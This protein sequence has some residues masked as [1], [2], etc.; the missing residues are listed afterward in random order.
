MKLTAVALAALLPAVA[1]VT[2]I[3][4][5]MA[6]GNPSAPVTIQVYSDYECPACKTFHDQ[7]LPE[8]VR[9][10]VATGKVYLIYRN[11]PLPMHPYSRQ[12]AGYACAAAHLKLFQPVAD[13]LFRNQSAWAQTGKVWEYVASVLTE[14]QQKEVETMAKS[15]EVL[16]EIQRDLTA[17]QR[18]PV[19]ST[20][21]LIVSHGAKKYPVSGGLNYL[22][23]KQLIND[24]A[25]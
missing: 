8:V 6:M 3:D 17:G 24:V 22:L 10:Y 18:E 21:T 9:D 5:G 11:F 14:R 7:T 12:A 16:A 20:P 23:L 4:T 2:D 13:A 25:K 15:P 19:T 1:A